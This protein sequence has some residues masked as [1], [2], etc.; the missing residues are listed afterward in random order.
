MA[1]KRR[2][3]SRRA[4][5]A[6]KGW[7]ARRAREAKRSAAAKKGARTR[8]ERRAAAQE[9]ELAA[10]EIVIIFDAEEGTAAPGFQPLD[11][12]PADAE[13][14]LEV[15][16]RMP[17]GRVIEADTLKLPLAVELATVGQVVRNRLREQIEEWKQEHPEL[18]DESPAIAVL[19]AG[20]KGRPITPAD[21]GQ[22]YHPF[23]AH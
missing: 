13:L 17:G 18:G 23:G 10:A 11:Q 5:A 20:I 14:Q 3:Q 1:K 22:F 6:R 9:A 12:W 21:V 19:R 15:E 4:A 16:W 2:P 8:A 7:R